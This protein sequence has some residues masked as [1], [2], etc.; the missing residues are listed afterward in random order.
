[1]TNKKY[2][3]S[4]DNDFPNSKVDLSRLIFEIQGSSIEKALDFNEGPVNIDDGYC[5]VWFKAE[6]STE[7]GYALDDLISEHSGESVEEISLININVPVTSNGRPRFAV[8]KPDSSRSYYFSHNWCDPTT[9]YGDSVRVEDEVAANCGDNRTYQL[10][11]YNVIDTFHGKIFGE[12]SLR[13]SNGCDYRVH[14]AVNNVDG[15]IEHDPHYTDFSD[16]YDFIVDYENGKIIFAD[17][18][19]PTDQVMVTYHYENGSAF[20]A[21]VPSGKKLLIEFAEVQ[22]SKDIN[23]TDTVKY[24]LYVYNPYYPMGPLRVPYGEPN[25]YK[26]MADFQVEAMKSFPEF[27]A[28]GKPGNWRGMS[29]PLVILNWDYVSGTPLKSSYGSEVRIW[30]EHDKPFEGT[31]ASLT[32]YGFEEDE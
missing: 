31:Y 1:M 4:I 17:E 24:Q 23:P 15:Y 25:V 26:T 32:F 16:G 7:D 11:H 12:D 22:F 8:E 20:H 21:V 18:R 29:K 2:S 13:D 27:P 30:L 19:L 3:Y 5:D 14:V 6:L 28:I 9:W 10:D